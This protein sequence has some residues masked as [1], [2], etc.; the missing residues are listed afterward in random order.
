MNLVVETD[1]GHDPDDFFAILYLIAAGVDIRCISL[2]P[3]DPDQVALAKMI[4]RENG[5]SIPIGVSQLARTENSSDSLHH[6]ILNKHGWDTM[7]DGLGEKLIVETFRKYPE[8]ELFVIGPATCTGRFLATYPFPVKRATMQGGFLGHDQHDFPC[9]RIFEG[10]DW[11]PTYNL[12]GDRPGGMNFIGGMIEERRFVGKNICHTIT[13]NK[14]KYDMTDWA[15]DHPAVKLFKEGIDLLL[16]RR[17]EKKFHDPTAAVLH[18]HPK[19]AD[20]VRGKPVKKDAGW[21]TELRENG[22]YIAA[23]INYSALWA[24]FLNWN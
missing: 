3:G 11:M 15:K 13:Y 24:N 4:C 23:D 22:D 21:G 2:V 20:W 18:L 14:A 17:T 6:A 7:H 19:I 5:L 9:Q 8:S 16:E 1:L 12:N 10:K